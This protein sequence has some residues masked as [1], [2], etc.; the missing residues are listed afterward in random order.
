MVMRG[1]VT[2]PRS[3]APANFPDRRPS[4]VVLVVGARLSALTANAR[5]HLEGHLEG[6]R[7]LLPIR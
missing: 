5:G 3:S 1:A 4:L 2:S 7:L 6:M